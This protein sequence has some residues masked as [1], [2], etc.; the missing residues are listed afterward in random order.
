[1]KT[2]LEEDIY[3]IILEE[4]IYIISI[5]YFSIKFLNIILRNL[6]M[7]N[8]SNFLVKLSIALQYN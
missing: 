5:H 7:N 2:K 3:Y 4:N 1:M 8:V 6:F